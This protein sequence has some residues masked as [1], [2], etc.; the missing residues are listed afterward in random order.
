[1]I[2]VYYRGPKSNE[3]EKLAEYKAGSWLHVENPTDDDMQ[4]LQQAHGLDEGLLLDATDEDEMPRIETEDGIT[5][6][7]TRFAY[8]NSSNR[9][10]TSPL[11]FAIGTQFFV[12]LSAIPY[13]PI[14]KFA[15]NE[16]DYYTTRKGELLLDL[17][18]L[19]IESYTTQL[20]AINRQIRAA[21]NS[22]NVKRISNK[23]FVQFV[24]IED[25]LNE[26]LGDLIPTNSVLQKLTK[27][28]R[29]IAFDEEDTDMV[30]DLQ[31]SASQLIDNIKGSLKTIV[32]IREAYSNITTNNL[33]RQV[34]LLTI[35]TVVLTIPT[36]VGSFFGMNVP[37]PGTNDVHAFAAIVG[38]TFV[39]A[40][41]LLVIFRKIRWL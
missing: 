21:R 8:K 18:E 12:S 14:H 16:T 39:I 23:D 31:L 32:N 6:I 24:E 28:R 41:L 33:N 7:Y 22:L 13:G 36:I 34:S 11:M 4:Y 25:V 15:V 2:T 40:G 9:I 38:G 5:Y 27:K 10:K 35:L 1:M 30:E 20:N 26:F 37:V 19:S 3:V 17:L 29:N